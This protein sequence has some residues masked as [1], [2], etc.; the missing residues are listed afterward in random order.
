MKGRSFREL[1]IL[2]ER[3]VPA[4]QFSKTVIGDDEEH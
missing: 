4:R 2:F 3:G 1:D